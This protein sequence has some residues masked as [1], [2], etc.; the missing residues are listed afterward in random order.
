MH[1]TALL[2]NRR[3]G[4]ET[5]EHYGLLEGN[6]PPPH[7]LGRAIKTRNVSTQLQNDGYIAPDI[8]ANNKSH[9]TTYTNNPDQLPQLVC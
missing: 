9:S 6:L 4:E 3:S 7:P 8:I 1:S 2:T 5:R